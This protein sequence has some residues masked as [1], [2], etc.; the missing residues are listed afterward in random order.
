MIV[1]ENKVKVL[2]IFTIGMMT[3]LIDIEGNNPENCVLTASK[4]DRFWRHVHVGG[5]AG[6]PC[7]TSQESIADGRPQ[8]KQRRQPQQQQQTT[9]QRPQHTYITASSTAESREQSTITAAQFN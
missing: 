7:D 5:A 6:S 3:F 9:E 4:G 2:R 1:W 8:K